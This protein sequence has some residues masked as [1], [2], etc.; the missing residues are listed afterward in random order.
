MQKNSPKRVDAYLSSLGYCSRKEAKKF[1]KMYDVCINNDRILNPSTKAFHNQITIN[2]EPLDPQT[3][4]I[5]MNKPA[6][7]IC[8]HNDSGVLIY[9]L[10]PERWQKRNPKLSTVGRL[11]MDTT[12][13]IIITD[14]GALNNKLCSPKSKATKVYEATLAQPLSG[15]EK[16]IFESGELLLNSETK[17][18]LPAKLIVIS[19]T[20][21]QLEICEGRYHQVKRMFA[22]VGNKVL[23]L[24]RISFA[25]IKI[26]DLEEK[27]YKIISEE[28]ISKIK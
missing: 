10:L 17:P 9:S 25:G 11:D 12:G 26:D 4:T 19:P 3:I 7:V 16:E 2:G 14:D 28:S 22:A 6:G 13:A 18:L 27:E 23:K 24:H 8:S 1:L 20:V 5:I 15:N 21:V